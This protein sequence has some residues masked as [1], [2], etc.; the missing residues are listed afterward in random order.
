MQWNKQLQMLKK[1]NAKMWS[2]WKMVVFR[3]VLYKQKWVLSLT[4]IPRIRVCSIV[5]LLA[6][7]IINT[8]L[9]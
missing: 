1:W 3:I 7:L 4:Q 6:T 8:D 5:Q 2:R 9:Q